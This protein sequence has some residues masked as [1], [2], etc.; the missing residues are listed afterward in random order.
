MRTTLAAF[1]AMSVATV[2][3]AGTVNNFDNPGDVTLS[4]T[5]AAGKWYTDRYAPATFASGATGGGRM[6]VLHHGLSVSDNAAGRPGSFGSGFY[7]TQGRK[8]DIGLVGAVQRLAIELFVD[9]GSTAQVEAGMWGVGKNSGG[10]I[11]SYPILA[12]I[13]N[14]TNDT[15]GAGF[16]TWNG[17]AYQF[18]A[19][20][21]ANAWNSLEIVLTVGTGFETF[22][23]GVSVFTLA[24]VNT[25]S[26]DEVI[27]NS[28]NFLSSSTDPVQNVYWDNFSAAVIP[29]P[30]AGALG[31][32]GVM[33][34]GARRRRLA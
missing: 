6:G 26:L 8:Y 15:A 29:L 28:K 10:S 24:D 18:V 11:S 3:T 1:A 20:G 5:Q 22:L 31:M 7:D 19:A 12:Y 30:T 25:V 34:L 14:T 17:A 23:N 33:V 32:A 9:A 2:A 13:Q 4:P 27:L 16:Y 21:G